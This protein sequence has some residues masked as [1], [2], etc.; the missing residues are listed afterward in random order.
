MR[1]D[2]A[3]AVVVQSMRDLDLKPTN[4]EGQQTVY[5]ARLFW[6][7]DDGGWKRSRE[8]W[9]TK[10]GF[11]PQKATAAIRA[12][13]TKD[14]VTLDD[15]LPEPD[16]PTT[17]YFF[18][19]GERKL[20]WKLPRGMFEADGKLAVQLQR[21]ERSREGL[22]AKG[23]LTDLGDGHYFVPENVNPKAKSPQESLR[24]PVTAA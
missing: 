5:E 18:A 23:A 13:L 11:N 9:L 10:A 4:S 3:V 24:V 6:L 14:G 2:L 17:D 21:S 8:D 12:K 7:K 15:A 19:A 1:D 20:L 16:R 22:M